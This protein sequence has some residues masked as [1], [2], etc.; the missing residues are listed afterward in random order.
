MCSSLQGWWSFDAV[1]PRILAAVKTETLS[2]PK[3]AD[4][5][6]EAFEAALD[7]VLFKE[8]GSAKSFV[9]SYVE[10]RLAATEDVPI[11]EYWLNRKPAFHHLLSSLPLEW[12]ERFP[13]M[14]LEA[15]RT[16]FSMAAKYGNR[17]ELLALIDRRWADAVVDSGKDTEADKRARARKKF[18]QINAFLYHA[19]ASDAAWRDLKLI[20]IQSLLW[21]IGW[22]AFDRIRRMT[23]LP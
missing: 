21:I 19:S 7:V 16:L 13:Q 1:D 20:R 9:R 17:D 4:G 12:L 15:A 2:Y 18:W 14:P 6:D 5:E 10:Q 22:G 3:F 11:R 23:V 8:S